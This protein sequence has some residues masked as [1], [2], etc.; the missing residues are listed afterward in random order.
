VLKPWIRRESREHS[1]FDQV[2]NLD[3]NALGSDQR[4]TLS[5]ARYV[6]RLRGASGSSPRYYTNS[7]PIS[8]A[9]LARRPSC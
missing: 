5:D 3:V 6:C 9:V 4:H 8:C 7:W 1:G 2:I